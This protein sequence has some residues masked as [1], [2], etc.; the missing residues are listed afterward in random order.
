[1]TDPVRSNKDEFIS[2][3]GTCM[4][5]YKMHLTPSEQSESIPVIAEILKNNL[6]SDEKDNLV[7]A[8]YPGYDVF[9]NRVVRGDDPEWQ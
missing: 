6:Y 8:L 7:R 9:I 4:S 1:M 5:F 2:Y 3:L